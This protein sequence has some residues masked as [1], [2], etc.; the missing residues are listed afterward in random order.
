MTPNRNCHRLWP[1]PLPTSVI[2]SPSQV[3]TSRQESNYVAH[4]SALPSLL[5]A[6]TR[7]PSRLVLWAAESTRAGPGWGGVLSRAS[8]VQ[9]CSLQT[10]CQKHSW[11][12]RTVLHG[13]DLAGW[14]HF[15]EKGCGC[16]DHAP[17]NPPPL[18][19]CSCHLLTSV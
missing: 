14:A 12:G 15:A 10:R 5:P 4:T 16:L 19:R 1:V 7:G 13:Q 11:R 17:S 8:R 18:K 9:Q 3:L 6:M 2:C